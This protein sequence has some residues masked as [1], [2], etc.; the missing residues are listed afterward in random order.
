MK[1]FNLNDKMYIKIKDKGW[2]HLKNT[3]RIDYINVV[4]GRS[5]VV[6]EDELWYELQGHEVFNLFGGSLFQNELIG[7]DIMFNNE[8]LKSNKK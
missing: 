7:I 1:K 3:K 2:E 8:D 6:I 4:I 5:A